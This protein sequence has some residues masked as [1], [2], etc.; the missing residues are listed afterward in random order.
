MSRRSAAVGR[1]HVWWCKQRERAGPPP[2]HSFI[3][4]LGR[5]LLFE[6]HTVLISASMHS[7]TAASF[8]SAA[9][10]VAPAFC[11]QHGVD[12]SPFHQIHTNESMNFIKKLAIMFVEMHVN[13]R[14]T[15]LQYEEKLSNSI[16]RQRNPCSLATPAPTYLSPHSHLLVQTM[17]LTQVL[18]QRP[19]QN[20]FYIAQP[21][22]FPY[23]E[24]CTKA[25]H[26][27]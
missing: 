24:I 2:S 25:R 17:V 15:F 7:F 12:R 9:T 14:P 10:G 11:S 5:R 4:F 26:L 22:G 1:R 21:V 19:R 20:G 3:D 27:L 6:A 23:L 16:S 18:E 13:P 8:S